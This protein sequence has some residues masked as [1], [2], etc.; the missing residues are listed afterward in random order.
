VEVLSSIA[1]DQRSV[2]MY[3]N[4]RAPNYVAAL[5]ILCRRA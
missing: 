4:V 2:F 3:R 1:G 5:E